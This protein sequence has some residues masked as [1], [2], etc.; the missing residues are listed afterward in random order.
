LLGWHEGTGTD[1]GSRAFI[2]KPSYEDMF[3]ALS[4]AVVLD[5]PLSGDAAADATRVLDA[6]R[7]GRTF[8]VVRAMA[9]PAS[10]DFSATAGGSVMR[11]GDTAPA[12]SPA[13]FH[14]RVPEAP[15]AR[16]A[17]ICNGAEVAAGRGSASYRTGAAASCRV[18]AYYPGRAMPWIVS[19]A[20]ALAEP[21]PPAPAAPVS[22]PRAELTNL[23]DAGR[24]ASEHDATSTGTVAVDGPDV[25]FSFVLGEG[26]PAGQYAAMSAALDGSNSYDRVELTARAD[27]PIRFW[28]QVRLPVGKDGL[29]W[30]RSIYMDSTPRTISLPIE[31]FTPVD[32]PSSMQPIAARLRSLL[33]VVDTVNSKPG[34]RGTIWLSAIGLAKPTTS[35]R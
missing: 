2:S 35:G 6:L 4:Q 29:R 26:K 9:W 12:G 7:T 33:L 24:W 23:T 16:V 20:I 22:G 34:R 13:V 15:G 11:M 17:I 27:Q 3:R 30:E 14:A 10:L 8:S 5:A 1:G 28:V 21:A 19:N 25:K 32:K 18:E 31:A